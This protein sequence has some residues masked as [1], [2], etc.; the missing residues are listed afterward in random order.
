VLSK[1]KTDTKTQFIDAS[2]L[3]KKET[4]N[5]ILTDTHIEQIMQAF[6]SKA[7]IEHFAQSVPFESIKANDYNLSVSSYIAAKDNREVVD[8]GALNAELKITVAK[9][10]RLR[11]EIDAIVAEIEGD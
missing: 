4:N 9:I 10:D 6:D 2:G 11:A 1:H 7:N 5:N 8:I 3:F